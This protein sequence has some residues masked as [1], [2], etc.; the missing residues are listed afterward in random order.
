MNSGGEINR[1]ENSNGSVMLPRN[2]VR[3]Q[4]RITPLAILRFFRND[5]WYI[6]RPMAGTRNKVV[7]I[8]APPR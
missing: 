6:A 7:S 2:A 1:K 4:V 5:V 8:C 3:Q